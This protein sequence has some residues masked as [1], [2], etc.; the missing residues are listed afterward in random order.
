[1]RNVSLTFRQAVY[2]QETNEV[3][4]IL[5]EISH[6]SLSTI[7]V[8]NNDV[9]I[10]SN[11]NVY[12]AY[13]FKIELPSDEEGDVPTAQLVID[14]VDQQLT[15]SIRSITTPPTIRIMVILASSP[16]TIEIDMPD[17]LL[18]NINYNEYTI[19]GTI[20]IEN[21]M[22]EPFPGDIF[23]PTQFPGLF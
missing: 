14:N 4:L 13:N 23:T 12:T 17:F 6:T 10:T 8:C 7:R 21:F 1:M 5:L 11:G 22:S 18:T 9:D 20:S 16:N 19:T 15:F 2:T 3:F